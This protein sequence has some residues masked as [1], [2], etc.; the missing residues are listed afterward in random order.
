[1]NLLAAKV[2]YRYF[3]KL[4][5]RNAF[6]KLFFSLFCVR[7]IFKRKPPY[8]LLGFLCIVY[9]KATP[10]YNRA[11]NIRRPIALPELLVSVNGEANFITFLQRIYFM[12]GFCS[13]EIDCIAFT[14]IDIIYRNRKRIAVISV[15]RKNSAALAQQKLL[16]SFIGDC[17]FNFS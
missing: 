5:R 6:Y 17:I 1:M 8:L 10:K 15:Y 13:M 4:H 3:I 2:L 9:Q 14:V 7:I 11:L 12:P 16:C